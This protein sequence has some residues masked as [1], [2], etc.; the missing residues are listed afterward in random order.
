MKTKFTKKTIGIIAC[1]ALLTATLAGGVL[2][3]TLPSSP[4][5]P[6]QPIAE[7]TNPTSSNLS[8]QSISN[9]DENYISETEAKSV[10]LTHAGLSEA[11][12]SHMI[13]KLDY[14]DGVAEY[15]VEFWDGTTEYDYEIN[16]IT[17]AIIEYDYDM[18]SY[19]EMQVTPETTST[20]SDYISDTEAKSIA[21]THAGLSEAD[22]SHMICKLDYDDGVAEYEVEFWDGTTEYDY[23]I[24]AITGAI[25]GYDYD[26]ESYDGM[27]VTPPTTSTP[28][29][30][31]GEAAAKAIALAHAAISE[32]E[33]GFIK[34]EFDIDDGYAEYEIE[35]QI[36][37]TEYEYTIS[38]T[39]GTIWEHD[40]D[41]DD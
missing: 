40:I 11:D 2:A 35:W 34:C 25:I 29:N 36:G 5:N 26:M 1:T 31:I 4:F 32:S 37:R 23:E 21:L 22:V 20:P 3:L 33:A 17:G 24:N 13:C 15:E 28:T 14:D 30:Y 10:A 19:D 7:Q 41:Y 38:A 6:N 12:V 18:E 39:D 9:V 27:Q 16:A 8:G